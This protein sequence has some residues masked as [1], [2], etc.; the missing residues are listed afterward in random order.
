MRTGSSDVLSQRHRGRSRLNTRLTKARQSTYRRI[1]LE[2]LE[3]CTL[4]ATTPVPVATGNLSD[5]T[6]FGSVTANGNA[7]SPTIAVDPYDSQKLFAVW[8]VDLSSLTP[9]VPHTTAVVEGAYSDDG[10]N[11]WN[12]V[13]VSNPEL[14]PL[15]VN[16]NPPTAYVQVTDPSVA[17]D[18]VGNVY[19]SVLQSS[20]AADG[21]IV[22]SKLNFSGSSPGF[23]GQQNV[24]QWVTG[25]DAA[26]SPT[27]A[28][29]PG[30][31][32]SSLG[33][34]PAGVPND[35]FVNNV[36]I[37]WASIDTLPAS[38]PTN[39]NPNRAEIVVGT[40]ISTASVPNEIPLA[41]SAVTTVNLNG[42]FGAQRNAHPTL[43]ISPVSATQPGQVI[44]GW[45]DD[46]SLATN[47][48]PLSILQTSFV[49]PGDTAGFNVTDP[50]PFLPA[51][52]QSAGNWTQPTFSTSGI[53]NAGPTGSNAGP[54]SIA[55]ADVDG[56]NGSDIVVAD[57][58]INQIGEL[59][60]QGAGVFPAT[61]ATFAAGNSP[62][63]VVLGNITQHSTPLNDAAVA[64]FS[65][66]AS[67]ITNTGTNG[68]FGTLT[69]LLVVPSSKRLRS[70]KA[71]STAPD[72]RSWSQTRAAT[73]SPSSLTARWRGPLH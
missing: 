3:L 43:A 10:G 46:G 19:V 41:F 33:S 51:G 17:F 45:E 1:E 49:Q 7:N 42:N 63:G 13:V 4:L 27:L 70:R 44:I 30:N 14:D 28:V 73:V 50:R 65:G 55:V 61:A 47:S 8:G 9:T 6:G 35:P 5:L 59:L 31:F 16:A 18:S 24:Y 52:P 71:T 20:G 56:V 37:A 48:P 69:H 32:P 62:V 38:A 22:L 53:Y 54:M 66:G 60:N 15:T 12:G 39:F 26:T 36:Y 2:G 11:N 29:D 64:N 23:D 34:P 40:P 67:V 21:A 57:E 72:C 25:S 68:V 58:G